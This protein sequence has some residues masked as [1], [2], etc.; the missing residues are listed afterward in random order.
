MLRIEPEANTAGIKVIGCGGGGG[1]AVNNMVDAEIGGVEFI[2]CNTDNQALKNSLAHRTVQ[3]GQKLTSGLGAGAN[4]DIGHKAAME[5]Q[6]EIAAAIEGS[7]MVFVT[8]GMGGGTG[9]GAAPVVARCARDMGILTVGVITLPF[10][11]EGARRRRVAERGLEELKE[12]VDTL[13][14]IPNDKLLSIAHDDMTL[15]EAFRRADGVLLS[16]V[17]GISE[18][19]VKPGLINVDFA[20]VRTIMTDGGMALMGQGH[21]TGESRA[22]AAAEMAVA[23][24]LL[25][26]VCIRG[27]T[28][29][30]CNIT[31][32]Q[33]LKLREVNEAV[34]YVQDQAAEDAN[35]IFGAVIDMAAK[36]EVHVTVIATG[37]EQARQRAAEAA[38]AQAQR[39]EEDDIVVEQVARRSS[40]ASLRQPTLTSRFQTPAA[41][42]RNASVRATTFNRPAPLPDAASRHAGTGIVELPTDPFP[43]PA[44]SEYDTP[45]YKR[46][47]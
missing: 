34:A 40:A 25:E 43:G 5:S 30:L 1:N 19:I 29:I 44:H 42:R 4:P 37:G 13:I 31:G 32:G 14:V 22:L 26:D 33:D 45:A 12:A 15:Q 10:T 7:D 28:G 36:D 46:R 2:A 41:E 8:A 16:A 20:D 47:N 11:M 27:A 18:I 23:S 21:A 6:Q 3:L 38:A 17:R 9:T 24:P 39:F 35:I